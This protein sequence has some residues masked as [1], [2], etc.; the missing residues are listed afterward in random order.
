MSNQEFYEL[1]TRRNGYLLEKYR[2]KGE[3]V[4]GRVTHPVYERVELISILDDASLFDS[5]AHT[6]MYSLI[7]ERRDHGK[8]S[9]D[10]VRTSI[11]EIFR[12]DYWLK[13]QKKRSV[14]IRIE[15]LK[16]AIDLVQ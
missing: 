4:I 3:E 11:E 9:F 8:I 16:R 1:S 13:L 2:F 6:I 12:K 5:F 7:M 15:G 10:S 14:E